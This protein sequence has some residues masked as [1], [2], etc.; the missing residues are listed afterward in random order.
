MVLRLALAALC[1]FA[2][3]AC[4]AP[5]LLVVVGG[6]V[7]PVAGSRMLVEAGGG[8]AA[9]IAVVPF[10]SAAKGAGDGAAREFRRLGAGA[11][12]V[13]DEN[14]AAGSRAAIENATAIWF[15]G[16]A[17][18]R[19]MAKLR[20]LGLVELIRA[21]HVAGVPVMGTSA[22]AAVMS[23]TMIAGLDEQRK[24]EPLIAEGLGL[25]RPA[26]VDQHFSERGRGSRLARAVAAHPKL[27]GA[28]IDES[29]AVVVRGRSLEVIGKGAVTIVRTGR[30]DL[31]LAPGQSHR[32]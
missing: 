11:T 14:D 13:L 4:A 1:W 24:G 18:R 17:Q 29:T 10:G 25:W 32:W 19:L 26:I 20:E 31:R 12:K 22:G 2:A 8:R 3:A 28:G 23:A 6:G 30:Q 27:F 9:R 7:T 15:D 5:G 21:R 16:G